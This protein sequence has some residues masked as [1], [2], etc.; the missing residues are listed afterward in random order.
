MGK[1]NWAGALYSRV[2]EGVCYNPTPS[3]PAIVDQLGDEVFGIPPSLITGLLTGLAGAAAGA[4]SLPIFFFLWE[5][6]YH[7]S[8]EWLNFV[9]LGGL[10]G[11]FLRLE[12]PLY[13][14]IY[15]HK[16]RILQQAKERHRREHEFVHSCWTQD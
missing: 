5:P 1:K 9:A 14:D 15:H 16:V 11:M 10:V 3:N 4:V 2:K 7:I 13:K 12:Q 8:P 6:D